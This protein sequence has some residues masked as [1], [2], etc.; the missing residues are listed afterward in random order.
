MSAERIGSVLEAD[1]AL[2]ASRLGAAVPEAPA[3]ARERWIVRAPCSL[4]VMGGIAEYTGGLSLSIPTAG[5][6]LVTALPRSDEQV[7]VIRLGDGGNG[8]ESETSWPLALFYDD[9]GRIAPGESLRERTAD[10]G[11]RI[12]RAVLSGVWA[13]LEK[14]AVPHLG[15]GCTVVV[16]CG[17]PVTTERQAVPAVQGA[18]IAALAR[19]FDAELDARGMALLGQRAQHAVM[20][21]PSGP[22]T[23]AGPLLGTPGALLQVSCQP[24]EVVGSRPLAAG[25]EI[26]G[27]DC[28]VAHPLAERKYHQARVTALMG[29]EIV[30]RLLATTDGAAGTWDG[31]LARVSVTDFVDRFRDRLPTKVKGSAYLER[32]GPL[33]DDLAQIE[34]AAMYKVRSRTEHHIYE[35]DRARQFAE[36]L[37]RAGRTGERS[38]LL[39]AGELMYASHWSYGQRCGLGSIETDLVVN[40]LRAEGP[41]QG[42]FGARIC[43]FGGGGVVVGLIQAAEPA[44][45]AVQRA[46]DTYQQRTGHT[47]KMLP[48]A[49]PGSVGFTA[50]RDG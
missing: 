43:G 41:D 35:N 18:A 14:R 26:L 5:A 12:A 3:A 9:S 47:A 23:Q 11:G 39:E 2:F 21:C 44:R 13:L 24:F 10:R 4:D 37:A 29:R 25:V 42:V 28:G 22:A 16:Q 45:A 15:G 1:P 31:Y 50:T 36:R 38:A 40:L 34:P 7:R 17:C 6:V 30:R 20:G 48:M 46:V 19:L 8:H 27:I 49:A 33:S 32:F